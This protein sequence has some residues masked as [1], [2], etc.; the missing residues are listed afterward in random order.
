MTTNI[1]DITP[2]MSSFIE[3]FLSMFREI[4]NTL[5]SIHFFGFSLL[6]YFIAL[7]V[8]LACIPLVISIINTQSTLARGRSGVLRDRVRSSVEKRVD[9]L[10]IGDFGDIDEE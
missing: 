1:Y 4:Y 5:S 10:G 9:S 7:F 6:T 8:L 2:F 3:L